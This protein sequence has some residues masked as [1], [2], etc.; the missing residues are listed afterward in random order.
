[1]S[2]DLHAYSQEHL[3]IMVNAKFGEETK[4]LVHEEDSDDAAE[5]TTEFRF[6]ASG[7]SALAEMSTAMCGC[8]ALHP[9]PEDEDSDDYG[10]EEHYVEAHGHGPGTAPHFISVMKGYPV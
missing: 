1:M 5:L 2:R 8:Q 4:S 7:K 6:V 10:G 9:D 3:Y